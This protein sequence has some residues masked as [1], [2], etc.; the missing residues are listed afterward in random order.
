MRKK[1]EDPKVLNPL[2]SAIRQIENDNPILKKDDDLTTMVDIIT[3]CDDPRFLDLPNNGFNLWIAQRVI[4]KCFYMGSKGNE[5]LA[6][7][8]EEWEWLYKYQEDE[9]LDEVLYKTNMKDVIRKVMAMSTAPSDKKPPTFKELHLV[10]G[11]RA[12]KTISAS[13]ITAYEV[14]KLIVINN[15]DPHAYY[16]LPSDDEIAIINVAL[17]QQQAGRLFG[18]IQSRLRNSAFFKGRIAKETTSEIR[19]YT[20]NDLAR[21][22]KGATLDVPG[23]ILILCGH[24]NP[25]SLAGFNAILILF[26]ELAFYDETGKVTGKYFYS[27]LKPSLTH[28]N[29][30]DE[31]RLVEISSPNTRNGIFYEIYKQAET[32][33]RILSF[34]L[35]TW[36]TNP[37]V[38]Y[39]HPELARDRK[40]NM[41]MFATEYGAQWAEGGTYGNFFE[42]ELVDRCIRGDLARH[43]RQKPG[44]NYYLHVDPS[45]GGNNYAAVLVAKERYTNYMGKKR[46]RCILAG[47]WIW[48]P[49]PNLGLLY[50]QIDQDIISICA[51]FHP[52]CVSYD[53]YHSMSSVQLLRSH[54]IPTKQITFNRS[55]K[56]KLFQNLKDMMI[57]QPDPEIHLYSDGGESS[58]LIAEL[59][60]LKFKELSR[61]YSVVPDKHGDVTTDDLCVHPDT[62]I[63]SD[64]PK[65]IKDIDIGDKILTANG[66]YDVVTNKIEHTKINKIIEVKPHYGLPLI[67]TDNHPVECLDINLQRCWKRINELVETDMLV[68]SFPT[69][70]S[71][72]SFDLSKY[73]KDDVSKRQKIDDYKVGDKIRLRNPNSKWHNRYV[74]SDEY[75]AYICGN[76]LA[77][78]NISD[79]G[80]CFASHIKETDIHERLRSSIEKVFGFQ[81]TGFVKQKDSLGAQSTVNSIIVRDLFK[82][83]F[84][85]KKA[86]NK[87]IPNIIITSPL[88]FQKAFIKGYWDGDGFI[89]ST[90]KRM[91]FTTSSEF[92]ALQLQQVLF[93][94]NIVSSIQKISRKGKTCVFRNKKYIQE[95]LYNIF[96][97]DSPSFCI[98]SDILNLKSKKKQ[99]IYHKC[100]YKMFLNEGFIACNIYSIKE[101]HADSVINLTVSNSHSYVAGCINSHNCDCLAGAVSSATEIFKMGLPS[102]AVVRTGWSY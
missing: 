93:R 62:V 53:D 24:S 2:S 23:S 30:F 57:Y 48:R 11:R 56:Q 101:S 29:Q 39:D 13:I 84:L 17:S 87:I 4:L 65:K 50:H 12:S 27:R 28:F 76:F 25:D 52:M 80:I 19:L 46:S 72:F 79:H 31:G 71:S 41:D 7:T 3:F 100:K 102:A 66:T 10:M 5:N 59:K 74:Y 43:T 95:N 14:Y 70:Q 51:R 22:A 88:D 96:I 83:I 8:Q 67:A 91:G 75:F 38:P 45:K 9:T 55:I 64:V 89:D 16:K 60:A 78:G 69:D 61:G 49:V 42:P 15:G 35:P 34:Q 68:R 26:D 20:N 92:L 98:L 82:D 94:L 86:C 97:T 73:V 21:K 81:D 18:Q 77:E 90:E 63:Y 85:G 40:S 58:L 6:L 1:A 44:M 47:V 33:D 54:G 99:S 36:R 37:G 32:D